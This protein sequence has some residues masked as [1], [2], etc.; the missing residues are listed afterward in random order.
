MTDSA[1]ARSLARF[2]AIR[3]AAGLMINTLF[4][5]WPQRRRQRMDLLELSDDH[6]KDIGVTPAEARREAGRPFWD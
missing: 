6:L 4:I 1:P 3:R 5:R 2:S